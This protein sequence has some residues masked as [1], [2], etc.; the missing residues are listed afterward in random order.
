MMYKKIRRLLVLALALCMA[1]SLSGC[2]EMTFESTE[3]APVALPTP[4]ISQMSAPTGDSRARYSIRATLYYRTQDGALS[5][6]LR[7]IHVDENDDERELILASLL[8]TPYSSSGLLPIAPANTRVLRVTLQNG[9]LT[10]DLSAEALSEG[11]ERF[12]T[13][14]AAIARTMLA[15]NG[16]QAVNVLVEGRAA[17]ISGMPLGALTVQPSDAAAGFVQQL[18]EQMLIDSESGYIERSAVAYLPDAATGLLLPRAMPVRLYDENYISPVLS[19]FAQSAAGDVWTAEQLSSV[20][21]QISVT[22]AGER[23]LTVQIP[24]GLSGAQDMLAPAIGCTLT[25]IIPNIDA[26][27]FLIGSAP[28]AAAGSAAADENGL[29]A[30]DSLRAMAA[31]SVKMYYKNAQGALVVREQALSGNAE[32]A[33]NLLALLMQ[34]SDPQLSSVFPESAHAA[35]I[36]GVRIA[37]G[38]AHV[39]LSSALY[40][41]CQSLDEA[42]ERA[43]IYAMVNTLVDNLDTVSAVQFYIAGGV[44]DTFAGTISILTPLIANPGIAEK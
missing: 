27:R 17:E 11:E 22:S 43:L 8:E 36:L 12:W 2:M 29:F 25:S 35:D 20:S 1:L 19:A 40:S 9:V 23:L 10:V 42:Q 7:L 26:V 15:R 16:I 6:A 14:R 4:D 13:A 24:E 31:A 44:A 38:I 41:A 39:N 33:R 21:A 18:S 32:N 30:P 28:I 5:S 34:P 3:G 37:D